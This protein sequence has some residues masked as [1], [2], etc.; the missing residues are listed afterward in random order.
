MRS[1][2]SSL[3]DYYY[4]IIPFTA[5][6]LMWVVCLLGLPLIG[7]A[8]VRVA[9]SPPSLLAFLASLVCI[10]PAFAGLFH[11]A[12]KFADGNNIGPR[13]FLEGM[14]T[15][16]GRAWA[17]AAVDLLGGGIIGLNFWFYLRQPN[18][19]IKLLALLFLYVILFWLALQPYLFGLLIFQRDKRLVTT[20][21]NASLLVLANIGYTLFL[22]LV[23]A[24]FLAFSIA[25]GLPFVAF[26]A[27][28]GALWFTRALDVLL[29]KY[30][31]TRR[32]PATTDGDSEKPA[33]AHARPMYGRR[34]EGD[35]R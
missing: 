3:G 16:F 30:P 9:P 17:L 28:V 24:I 10:P 6:N 12:R 7:G 34:D 1:L 15:Y 18:T 23:A 8:I 11:A 35:S 21:R 14:R 26:T 29:A 25:F 19:A 4:E 32:Q 22:L 13:D 31:G 33:V 2:W 20:F 27:I 5:I